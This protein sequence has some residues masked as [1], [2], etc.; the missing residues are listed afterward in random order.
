MTDLKNRRQ[1]PDPPYRPGPTRSTAAANRH[2]LAVPMSAL[3][4]SAPGDVRVGPVLAIPSVLRELGVDPAH[5]FMLAG[6]DPALFDDPDS[7]MPFEALAGLLDACVALSACPHF[8]LLVGERFDLQGF[9]ALGTLIRNAPTVGAA[10][11]SL[12]LHL[13]RHDRGAAPVLLASEGG[14]VILG[15]SIYRHG[16]AAN[17]QVY[18]AAIAIGYRILAELCGPHWK[19]ERVQFAHRR[20]RSV[21]H[22]RRV[23]GASPAFDAEVSGI[24]FAASCLDKPIE[25]ADAGLYECVASAIREA[26]ALEALS[27][28]EQV[29]GALHQMVLSGM[30]T[31]EAVAR[32]FGIHERTLRRRLAAEGMNLQ[33]LINQ[34]RFT[35]ARQLLQNTGLPVSSIAAALQY[36][37]ATAFSRAFRGWA[38]LSPKQWRPAAAAGRS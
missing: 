18:A 13:H 14:G 9:G 37:D 15:Y 36:T 25:G 28:G 4:M 5:A 2:D 11:R 27:L 19:P 22:Y 30:A 6:V 34:T 29:R 35:L 7:R 23:F 3:R 38:G 26:E 21:T 33:Q 12:V 1:L 31:G 24:V 16:M 20:P 32:A 17:A 8:G 10:M